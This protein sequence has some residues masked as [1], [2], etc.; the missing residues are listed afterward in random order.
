MKTLMNTIRKLNC[1]GDKMKWTGEYQVESKLTKLENT[2]PVGLS[3]AD[4]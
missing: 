1:L 4:N 2:E 3:T